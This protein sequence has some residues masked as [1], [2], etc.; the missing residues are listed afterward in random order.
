MH[1]LLVLVSVLILDN[2]INGHQVLQESCANVPIQE[3][4]EMTDVGLKINNIL[5]FSVLRFSTQK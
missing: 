2:G 1:L 4:L 3:N 5:I